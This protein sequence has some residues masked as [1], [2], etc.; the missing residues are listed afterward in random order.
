MLTLERLEDM[1]DLQEKL[2]VYIG[3]EDWRKADHNYPLC[4]HMECAELIDAYG[5][6][7]WKDLDKE[8]DLD[9]I[10]MELVD[11]WHFAMAFLMMHDNFDATV[12]HTQIL[13]AIEEYEGGRDFI[14]LCL[15]MG[16]S[17]LATG[18]FPYGNFIGLMDE[19]DMSFDDLYVL[20]VSKNVLNW[21]R[22][23]HGYKDGTYLKN[24][25]G[26]EDNEHLKDICDYMDDLNADSLYKELLFK[27]KLVT[28]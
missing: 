7:H 5:W 10:A 18:K 22:Q 27:Y 17:P 8:P 11:V 28:N 15:G 26:K 13:A 1:L 3:G 12:M 20:Y 14:E 2:E 21:F 6:K 4:I 16:Y 24:W 23:D 19:I 25:G 9:V